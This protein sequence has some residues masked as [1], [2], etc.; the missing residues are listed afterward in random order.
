MRKD[1]DA[2]RIFGRGRIRGG[3][4]VAT[5]GDH[6]MA[7]AFLVLGLGAEQPVEVDEAEMIGTSF[8]G[9][10]DVMRSLGAQIE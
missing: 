2:L 5:R 6:R 4:S 7:M 10:V 3:A 8:P 1:G 9:F